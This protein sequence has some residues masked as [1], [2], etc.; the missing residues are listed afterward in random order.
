MQQEAVVVP[1]P[2][3]AA[4]P[5][6]GERFRQCDWPGDVDRH[7]RSVRGFDA[8][9]KLHQSDTPDVAGVDRQRDPLRVAACL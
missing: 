9:S 8:G 3:V 4:T 1:R 2:E 5:L 7:R 6:R